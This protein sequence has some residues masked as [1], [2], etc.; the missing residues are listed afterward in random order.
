MKKLLAYVW[1]PA[2]I[3][4]VCSSNSTFAQDQKPASVE[5]AIKQYDAQNFVAAV[6]LLEQ[7]NAE[8]PDNPFILSR[9][10]FSLYAVSDTVKDAD[11]RKKMRER[12]REVLLKSQSLGDDSNLTQIT[13]DALSQEEVVIPFSRL[14]A[15]DAA[16]REGEAAFV[17]GDLD[18]ALGFYKKAL[19]LDPK[20]YAA[21]LFAGDS[22]YKKAYVSKDPQFRR[23]HFEQAA[24]WFAKA[25]AIDPNRE[26]A[27][28]YWGDALDVQ[29]RTVEARDKFVEAIV[30][31]P[32]NRRPYMGLMQWAERHQVSM[33]HPKIVVPT[34]ISSPK[35]G[36]VTITLDDKALAAGDKDATA[37]WLMYGLTRATWSS[38]KT[39]NSEKFAKAYPRE[40]I[41]RHSLA[42]EVE[43]LR[44]VAESAAVQLKEKRVTNLDPS[45]ANLIKLRDA[46]LLEAYVLFVRPNK[47]ISRDYDAYRSS[48][49]DQLRRYWLDVVIAK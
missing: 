2:L 32:F 7:A 13:L 33:G 37:A 21:A 17:R 43:A 38:S 14:N 39:G 4:I 10:G 23:E 18:A 8:R 12:A 11:G 29:G 35:A 25:I 26:T 24:I 20:L 22:E 41:Y 5:R 47:D 45:L 42:E 49:R 36:S 16:I 48:N 9:L 46:G 31:E 27:Y 6:P 40:T 15:A 19:E 30:A 44:M 1:L 34:A 3:L 28:R